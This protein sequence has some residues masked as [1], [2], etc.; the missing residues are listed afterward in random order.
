MAFCCALK[1]TTISTCVS[2]RHRYC[3]SRFNQ[4]KVDQF[5]DACRPLYE[6]LVSTTSSVEPGCQR[7]SAIGWQDDQRRAWSYGDGD[8]WHECRG[9]RHTTYVYLSTKRMHPVG[10]SRTNQRMDLLT[11]GSKMLLHSRMLPRKYMSN[12]SGWTP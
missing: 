6:G 1:A 3:Q 8:M 12:H 4:V 11:N 7:G 2:Q 5:F 9:D 10:Y